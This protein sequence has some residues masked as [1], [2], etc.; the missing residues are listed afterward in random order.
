MA[1][2]IG[3]KTIDPTQPLE[4]QLLK[5]AP[6]ALATA[7]SPI[8]SEK[9]EFV[10]TMSI[11]QEAFQY[12]WTV[13]AAGQRLMG[14]PQANGVGAHMLKLI[15]PDYTLGGGD[16]LELVIRNA[17]NRM[18]RFRMDVG[19]FRQIC[20]N[21]AVIRLHNI[22]QASETHK[23]TTEQWLAGA[24]Q[25]GIKGVDEIGPKLKMMDQRVLTKEEQYA[26]ALQALALRHDEERVANIPKAAVND[27]LAPIRDEDRGDTL[28]KVFHVTQEKLISG[29]Y[30]FYNPA[31]DKLRKQQRV[32]SAEADYRINVQ[33]SDLAMQLIEQ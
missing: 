23:H 31:G 15:H 16:H 3:F 25:S 2:A 26:F 19:Y 32:T 5:Y 33:L 28:W 7:P 20:S 4:A 14:N 8:V 18:A 22:L 29:R 17:H 21:G 9:Y 27:F 30:M 24:I 11:V 6:A 13:S 10:N 12:G 1:K